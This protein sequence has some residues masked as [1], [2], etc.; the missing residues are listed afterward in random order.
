MRS[1][2]REE[3]FGFSGNLAPC[4]HDCR[5]TALLAKAIVGASLISGIEGLADNNTTTLDVE[6][7]A[8]QSV[9]VY[10]IPELCWQLQEG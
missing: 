10:P 9:L 2:P 8:A 3:M 6:V 4:E 7:G 1:E 5:N